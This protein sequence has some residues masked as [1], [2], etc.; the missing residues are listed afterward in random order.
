MTRGL[1]R[2]GWR[3]I[4]RKGALGDVPSQVP[5]GRETRAATLRSK[6]GLLSIQ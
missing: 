6:E 3:V 5:R 4:S 2:I 1:F